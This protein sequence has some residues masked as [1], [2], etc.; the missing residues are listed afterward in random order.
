MR[1]FTGATSQDGLNFH[2]FSF[3][4][5][6]SDVKLDVLRALLY[7]ILISFL[8]QFRFNGNR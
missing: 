8:A 1:I 3:I 4:F 7:K 2:L 6:E 5:I